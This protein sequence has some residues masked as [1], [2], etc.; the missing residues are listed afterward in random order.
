MTW[1]V[2]L[3]LGFIVGL[4]SAFVWC[5]KCSSLGEGTDIEKY[6]KLLR[7]FGFTELE[8]ECAYD[9]LM[10]KLTPNKYFRGHF[11]QDWESIILDDGTAS[12]FFTLMH[13]DRWGKFIAYGAR[14]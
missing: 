6:T 12:K 4:V 14:A 3:Y 13:F 9:Q 5:W 10:E 1:G 7:G 11:Y 8:C 2:Y